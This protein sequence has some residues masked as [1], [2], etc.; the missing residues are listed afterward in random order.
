MEQEPEPA[1]TSRDRLIRRAGISLVFA[2]EWGKI[3]SKDPVLSGLLRF[4]GF[5]K[6]QAEFGT[7]M[8][9][10]SA[11]RACRLKKYACLANVGMWTRRGSIGCLTTPPRRQ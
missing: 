2:E 8:L 7:A 5:S 6:T 9:E 4:E 3:E 10:Q 1:E 11:F